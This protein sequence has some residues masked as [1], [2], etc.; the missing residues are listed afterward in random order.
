RK[1]EEPN[2]PYFTLEYRNQQVTQIQGKCNRQEVP[3]K[4]KQAVRQWQ[5]N[6][7]HALSS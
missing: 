1:K 2:L 7:Q 3:E 6:L 5:E 4:I